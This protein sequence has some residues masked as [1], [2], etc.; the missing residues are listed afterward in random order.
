MVKFKT[1]L[2]TQPINLGNI[3]SLSQDSPEILKAFAH[4]QIVLR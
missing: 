2:G 3:F 4:V 1:D